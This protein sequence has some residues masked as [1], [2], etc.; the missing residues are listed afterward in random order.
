MKENSKTFELPAGE[1]G[2]GRGSR[3]EQSK[4]RRG[5]VAARRS[6]Q[7]GAL[8]LTFDSHGLF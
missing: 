2:E 7:L 5:G 4:K 6:R 3:G 8:R 1:E